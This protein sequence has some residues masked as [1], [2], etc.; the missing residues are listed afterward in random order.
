MYVLCNILQ[1]VF[2]AGFLR[3]LDSQLLLPWHSAKL[4]YIIF[5]CHWLQDLLVYPFQRKNCQA[6][7]F[8]NYLFWT[9][10]NIV[11]FEKCFSRDCKN[12]Y[13]DTGMPWLANLAY[14][15]PDHLI[16]NLK[17]K[18]N[19]H[20]I[21]TT[22]WNKSFSSG[23]MCSNVKMCFSILNWGRFACSISES[24]KVLQKMVFW[25]HVV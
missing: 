5:C 18:H 1:G 17:H 8:W 6:T 10:T 24:I 4:R 21:M 23:K 7:W 2:I 16:Q 11:P 15:N 3:M 14:H 22:Q 20:D 13:L 12:N 25:L 9:M 19:S